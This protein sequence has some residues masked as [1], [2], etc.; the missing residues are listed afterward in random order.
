RGGSVTLGTQYQKFFKDNVYV[1]A[2]ATL[3]LANNLNIRGND[4][5]YSLTRLGVSKDTIST[6]KIDGRY[7]LPLKTTL[8]VGMGKYDKWYVGLE[9]EN[10][11]AIQTKN[12]LTTTNAGFKYEKSNRISLGGFYLPKINS[13][14][15]YWERVTYRAGIRFEKTGLAVDGSGNNT[16]FTPVNDFGMS[17]GLGLPLKQLSNVNMGFEFGRRGTTSNNLIQENYFNFSLSL[18][19]NASNVQRWFQKRKID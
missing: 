2:G 4:Y 8:G 7:K 10:R 6:S 19:L 14:S 12:L 16:N 13:I 1:N 15:N 17:F 9:Y 5:L 18:S 11:D 3:K